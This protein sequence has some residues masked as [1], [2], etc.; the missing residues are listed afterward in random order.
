[1]EDNEIKI[2]SSN[3]DTDGITIKYLSHNDNYYVKMIG[4]ERW[5]SNSY[6]KQDLINLANQILELTK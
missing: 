5:L 3:N 1:M 2:E 6:S 4:N